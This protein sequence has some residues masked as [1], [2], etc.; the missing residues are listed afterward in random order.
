MAALLA[1]VEPFS[2]HVPQQAPV[3]HRLLQ[4]P[5]QERWLYHL[6]FHLKKEPPF[7]DWLNAFF[8]F[9][10]ETHYCAG[11]THWMRCS[12]AFFSS[13][14]LFSTSWMISCSSSVRKL[15]SIMVAVGFRQ[16]RSSVEHNIKWQLQLLDRKTDVW[17][18]SQRA[19]Q[20]L[21]ENLSG[22]TEIARLNFSPLCDFTKFGRHFVMTSQDD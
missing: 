13:A 16:A 8:L 10:S 1:F 19:H 5:A 12:S 15:R 2:S 11:T 6:N 17:A 18:A 21:L 14:S 3:A 7:P 20:M 22:F 9:C 4:V